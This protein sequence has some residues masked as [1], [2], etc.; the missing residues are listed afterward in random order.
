MISTDIAVR[1]QDIDKLLAGLKD[2]GRTAQADLGKRMRKEIMPMAR[3]IA[4]KVTP[5]SPFKGMRQNYYGEVQW[6]Q[7][8]AK[9]AVTPSRKR[10]VW[11]PLVSVA[12]SGTPK[13]GFDYTENAGI[14]RRKPKP[15]SKTYQ[16]RGDS[17]ARSHNVTTQGDFLIRKARE[18]STFNFKAGHFAY[19]HFL[20]MKPQMQQ[21]AIKSLED[22]AAKFNIRI[23]N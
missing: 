19:G 10:G 12:L 11:S 1:K 21:V 15:K 6:V 3:V 16:R 5:S 9:I 8:T 4:G 13:L 18:V 22:T 23:G 20:R 17:Q 14:R 2:L 7:P